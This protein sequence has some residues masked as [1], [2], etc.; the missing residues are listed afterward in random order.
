MSIDH[1][2]S[3]PPDQ[4][5]PEPKT[6]CIITRTQPGFAG[7]PAAAV[8]LDANGRIHGG[9]DGGGGGSELGGGGKGNQ[10]GRDGGGGSV[11]GGGAGG[12]ALSQDG[13]PKDASTNVAAF[14]ANW[15]R[16]PRGIPPPPTPPAAAAAT[17]SSV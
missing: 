15:P 10:G 5:S 3:V 8:R 4:P 14:A 7:G 16:L 12:G 11:G 2:F 17:S 1:N 9:E 13:A 6:L